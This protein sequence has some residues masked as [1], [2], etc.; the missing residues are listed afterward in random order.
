MEKV[1]GAQ[2]PYE[3]YCHHCRVTFPRE[4]RQCIHCGGRLGAPGAL[5][6]PVTTGFSKSSDPLTT[7]H[8]PAA[9]ADDA[10]LEEDLG[11]GGMLLRRFG[12]LAV[13]ALLALM[14]VVSRL[15]E[16]GG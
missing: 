13:W 4:Q 2:T 15:C 12:G 11:A 7:R 3:V 10:D 14:A 16:Q 1:R 5:P 6:E 9:P 8:G